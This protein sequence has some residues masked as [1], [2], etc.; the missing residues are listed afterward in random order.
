MAECRQGKQQ[1]LLTGF[2]LL[3]RETLVYTQ[4]KGMQ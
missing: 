4:L 1:F 2:T 3:F